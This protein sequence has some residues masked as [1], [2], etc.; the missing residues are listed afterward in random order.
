MYV[1]RHIRFAELRKKNVT[2]SATFHKLDYYLTPEVRD[3][4]KM[5]WKR[6][7]MAP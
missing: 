4:L 5:L 1:P 6:T 2:R 7:E 3:I